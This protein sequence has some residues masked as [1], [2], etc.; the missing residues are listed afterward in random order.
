MK[1]TKEILQEAVDNSK[2][3]RDVLRYLNLKQAG[4]TQSYITKR[5]KEF[6]ID[7]TKFKGHAWAK[8]TVRPKIRNSDNVL[9]LRTEGDRQ[10]SHLLTRCLLE[11]GVQHVCSKCGQ[12]PEWLGNPLT[13]DVD[14]I[15]Q[16][17][18]DDRLENLRFLCPNCHSQYS[19]NLIK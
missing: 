14:H 5:I 3:F 6:Q 18:L 13:L 1:Y 19:R 8:D 7:T 2:S 12:S 15:N 9:V 16:N 10:K 11:S 4:G 17:W